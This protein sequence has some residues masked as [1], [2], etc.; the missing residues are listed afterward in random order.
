MAKMHIT[1][2]QKTVLQLVGHS[3]FA[4]P[5]DI[6]ND[7]DWNA[8]VRESTVQAVALL[9]FNDYNKLPI[10]K[11]LVEPLRTY[12]RKCTI[13]NV[14]CFNAHKYLHELMTANGIPYCILK[15]VASARCYPDA[16]LRSMGDVDF[17]VPSEYVDKAREVCVF[18]GLEIVEADHSFH[19]GMKKG[20]MSFE[21]HF[22]PIGVP[23]DEMR[24]IFLE[25]WSDICEKSYPFSDELTE[26]VVSSDFHHGFILLTHLRT[27]LVTSG[28]GLRHVCDWAV[29]VNSFTNEEFVALFEQKLKRVGLWKLAQALSLAAVDHLGMT[30]K[31]WMGDDHDMADALMEDVLLGG[32]FARRD[33]NRGFERV[34]MPSSND[35]NVNRSRIVNVFGTLNKSVRKHWPVASRIPLLY[36][37]GWV[38]VSLRF[39]ILLALGK[40]DVNVVNGF[41]R[42]GQRMKLYEDLCLFEPEE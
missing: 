38:Y 41:K 33:S 24:P 2:A 29:F 16:L 9:A 5:L 31:T 12:L 27:H 22:A 34:F 14:A 19:L 23:N 1:K 15:G 7:V 20:K 18:D 26:C 30:H 4:A 10:D 40:R 8:V 36:P 17:Y 32:N 37:F 25:Y 11:A 13:S 21:L 35:P 28:V 3:L 39:L 6:E 42:S